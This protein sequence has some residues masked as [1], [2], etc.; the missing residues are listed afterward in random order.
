VT[1]NWII[2]NGYY[3]YKSRISVASQT[4]NMQIAARA[5]ER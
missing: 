1:L 3:L 5:A 4:A 2:A